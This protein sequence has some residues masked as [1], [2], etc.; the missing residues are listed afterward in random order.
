MDFGM[1]GLA[2]RLLVGGVPLNWHLGAAGATSGRPAASPVAIEADRHDTAFFD[3]H[4]KFV[5]YRP[6]T[7]ILNNLEFDHADIFDDLP[8]IERQFHHLVRTV[9]ASG[10]ISSQRARRKHCPRA[11]PWLLEPD[12]NLWQR[13]I[14][15]LCRARCAARLYR[16]APRQAYSTGAM[17]YHRRTQPAQRTR[18]HAAAAH[19]GVPATVAAQALASFTNARRRMELRGTVARAGGNITIVRRLCLHPTAIRTTIDGLRQSLDAQGRK[20]DRILAVFEPRNNTMKLG[21]M[22]AQLP[23][24]L[25]Q[26]DLAFCHSGGLDWNAAEAL[27]GMGA[28]ASVRPDI[29]T[30]VQQVTQ[31]A[32]AGDHI[33]CMSNGG[34]GGIHAQLLQKL[35]S[36]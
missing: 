30:L 29:A 18:R 3:K 14:E 33:L 35:A 26:A 7:A 8:A 11:A 16:A 6:R 15:R 12:A 32:R 2:A 13:G 27:A 21:T 24:S 34:F 1:C 17:G 36:P 23:W 10:C 9:P 22:K 28:R 19:V 4:N 20:A 25:E 5:H 31:A